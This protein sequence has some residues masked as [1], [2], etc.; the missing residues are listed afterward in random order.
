MSLNYK[1]YIEEEYS[2]NE[3]VLLHPIDEAINKINV[4][5]RSEDQSNADSSVSSKDDPNRKELLWEKREED[6]V[7]KWVKDMK[8]QA[9]KHYKA[10]KKNKRLH[11]WITVPSILIPVIASGLTP[12]LQPYPYVSTGL[13]LTVGVL[14]GVNG[15]Y[16]FA[17][18]KEKHL[19]YEG[20]YSV[21]SIEIEKELCKPKKNRLACDVYLESISMKKTQLDLSAPLL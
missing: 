7:R 18:K 21:L 5:I 20:L 19:N 10:G 15:F 1:D 2:Q 11:E 17:S 16:N 8:E 3:N 13:M 14:T 4:M 12:L 9:K 6:V